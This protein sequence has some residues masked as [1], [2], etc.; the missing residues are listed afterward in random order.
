[1]PDWRSNIKLGRW[2]LCA[3]SSIAL[4]F[5]AEPAHA[6][7]GEASVYL[8]GSGGPGNASLPPAQR[9]L[10]VQPDVSVDQLPAPSVEV[11]PQLVS[12]ANSAIG[13]ILRSRW[14]RLNI[15]FIGAA[16]IPASG[17]CRRTGRDRRHRASSE[18]WRSAR[19]TQLR[20]L[21]CHSVGRPGNRCSGRVRLQGHH[22]PPDPQRSAQLPQK[23]RANPS[24]S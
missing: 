17:P 3:S 11:L 9:I 13:G 23:P 21:R 8:T 14:S 2:L 5:L 20:I 16:R 4:M 1:M 6:L 19:G 22:A 10:A 18:P 12:G 7:E 15:G 24:S